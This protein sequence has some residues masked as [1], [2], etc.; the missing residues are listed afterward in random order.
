MGEEKF[1]PDSREGGDGRG[2]GRGRWEMGNGRGRGRW[3]GRGCFIECGST[4]VPASAID[5]DID[6]ALALPRGALQSCTVVRDWIDGLGNPERKLRRGPHAARGWNL[7]LAHAGRAPGLAPPD[8]PRTGP[9]RVH[10]TAE[11]AHGEE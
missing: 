8:I 11:G 7:M 9:A 4:P 2:E 3:E 5:L 6:T 10:Q 1:R